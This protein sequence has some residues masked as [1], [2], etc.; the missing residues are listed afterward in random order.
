MPKLRSAMHLDTV[1]TFADR[2][3]RHLLFP[4]IMDSVQPPTPLRPSDGPTGLHVHPDEGSARRS[5]TSLPTS[6]NLPKLH[7]VATAGDAYASERQQWD[8]GA[9]DVRVEDVPDPTIQQPT[10]AL[11]G[12]TRACV[13]GSDLHPYHTS[14]ATARGP[15]GWAT[16]SSASSRTSAPTCPR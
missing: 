1:F 15:A 9:G 14:M 13:C 2:D 5:S 6:S 8:S 12:V 16:S 7:V 10:D 4:T 3:I 11:V